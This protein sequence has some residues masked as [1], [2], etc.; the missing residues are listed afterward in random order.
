MVKVK[1]SAKA[2]SKASPV[3]DSASRTASARGTGGGKTAAGTAKLANGRSHVG[4]AGG[5]AAVPA[6]T[7]KAQPSKTAEIS[8]AAKPAPRVKGAIQSSTSGKVSTSMST[9]A[10]PGGK[11][12]ASVALKGKTTTVAK[13]KITEVESKESAASARAA[14]TGTARTSTAKPNKAADADTKRTVREAEAIPT[15][16]SPAPRAEAAAE[17]KKRGRK[18]RAGAQADDESSTD[19]TEEFDE[20]PAAPAPKSDKQK[21]RDRKA[22]EKALLKE[23]AATQQGGSEE[24]LE[25]R[26]QKLKALIKLGKSRGYLTYAEIN[27]HLP[28]DMVD[29]ES[30]DT[31][32]ATLNDIGIAVY[33]QAPDAE[34]LLLNDNA[35]SV[36]TEEEAEEEAEAALSTVDSEFGRTTDPVRMYMREMGTVEL[37]TR[38]GEIEI[39]KRIEAGLK[40]MVMAISACPVTI[41]EILAMGERVANDEAKIDEYIDGLI[42]PNADAAEAAQAGDEDEDFEDEDADESGD[43]E[44][45]EDDDGS[46]SSA[47]SA[48][49]LEELKQ[50]ALAK[51]AIIGDQFEKMRRAFEKEGYKSKPYLKAQEA[52]Q[53]E[54]MT[55]RFTARN[56]ERLCDTLRGQVDEVRKLERAILNI[57]VDKCGMSRGDFVSRFPGNE[58]NLGW[59]NTVVADGKPYSAIVERNI[60]AVHELQQKLI[61]LQARVVLPLAELKDVNKK[62]SE[63]ERRA[64]EAKRE[65]TEANLR[66]VI[67]IAKKYTNR[68]LQFLDLIQEGNIGLM[69]AVDKFEYRRG[70]KFSTYATWWIRQAITRSIA[71]QARTIRIPV[72]MIET[73]NK[74]NRISRQILQ[75]TGNEPDPATLAEKMEMPED[76]IRKIMKIAKEPIS[77]ET[78]IGDDDDSHLGDFIEDTNTLAPAEAALHGSMRGVVKDVLD[79]LTP[80]EA[81][82]LRMRFGIEMSTDHTLEEVG[83][84]FDVTRERIRQIEAKALRKLRHPSRSDKLKSFLEGS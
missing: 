9:S 48:R 71:D 79:S 5:K 32:V 17:P 58:T 62:M 54:L 72:H 26:R 61:D 57:V 55:I 66:L 53:N 10:R 21:A 47:A 46:G 12:A 11:E 15:P 69:K 77:M 44:E 60:P 28:D 40:D 78:P 51:F 76:K 16:T 36:T 22:K 7:G 56:V 42:D 33:E 70:Y 43:E 2:G 80:R 20:A 18:P 68:G 13:S 64:R 25:A 59:I 6:K 39:A 63:G 38:E 34:T 4:Q 8:A 14:K 3:S 41:S 24:E 67:S 45:D 75:E 74:M 82:V 1:T 27:D 37:L 81:K 83:K 84:Q 52:I 35:P 49:Q 23:F 50:A 31:L 30:M 19:V 65:M 73:I 29:A